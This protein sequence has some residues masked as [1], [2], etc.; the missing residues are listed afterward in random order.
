[1]WSFSSTVDFFAAQWLRDVGAS[2]VTSVETFH[3]DIITKANCSFYLF[4][5]RCW[6]GGRP[7]PRQNQQETR[8]FSRDFPREMHPFHHHVA[9]LDSFEQRFKSQKFLMCVMDQ[10]LGRHGA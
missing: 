9:F 6:G 4:I 10:I 5:T 7:R 3:Y 2:R 1:M 8:A